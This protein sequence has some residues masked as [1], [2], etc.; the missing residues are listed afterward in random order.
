MKFDQLGLVFDERLSAADCCVRVVDDF[1]P[2]VLEYGTVQTLIGGMT[3][4]W[5]DRGL[6]Y[7][8]FDEVRS[9]ERVYRFFPATTLL[10]DQNKV[11]RYKEDVLRAWCGEQAI[12]VVVH[13]T[14]FQKSVWRA[15]LRIP[16]GHVA[17]YGAVAEYIGRPKAVRAVAQACAANGLAV[18]IPCHRVV[19]SD[20]SLS[21]YRWGIERKRALL[22]REAT[23]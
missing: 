8:G 20:G 23:S 19:R 6:C 17:S 4:V 5:C 15:L 12:D 10:R 14:P 1:V 21:G 16:V 3:L 11:E 22:E 7:L 2:E 9:L 18:A 13:G